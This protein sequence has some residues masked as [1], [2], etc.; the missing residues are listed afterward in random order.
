LTIFISDGIFLVIIKE[1][2]MPEFTT[3]CPYCAAKMGIQTLRCGSC[4]IE[5]T[6]DF[7]PPRLLD[8]TPEER[9][10]VVQFV[11]ASGSLK[12][13]A[14]VYGVSYP[15]VR[16]RLDRLIEKLR[17]SRLAAKD[18]RAAILDAIEQK[19]ITPT[20][21]ATILKELADPGERTRST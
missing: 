5:V 7:T 21:A 20:E 15:T 18:K 12:E 9:E 8:L 3:K 10:F 6:G 4:G 13:I 1:T 2:S 17:G 11:L 14:G 16:T 19:E